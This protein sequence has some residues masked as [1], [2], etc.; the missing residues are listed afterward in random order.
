MSVERVVTDVGFLERRRVI[1]PVSGDCHYEALTLETFNNH[2]L[3]LR[4]RPRKHQL[5][6]LSDDVIEVCVGHCLQL[7]ARY[8]ASCCC[9]WQPV[10]YT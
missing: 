9:C 3:L 10:T 4:R 8:D 6:M 1:H 7:T 5:R 2:Q